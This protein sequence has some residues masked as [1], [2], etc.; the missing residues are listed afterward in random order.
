[1][2]SFVY[3]ELDT[4]PPEI[5]IFAPSYT[6]TEIV[7]TIRIETDEPL[8]DYQE[9]YAIDSKGIRHDYTF[10]KEEANLLIGE[11]SFFDFPLGVVTMYAIFKDEVDNVSDLTSVSIMIRENLTL[12][13][14][15]MSDSKRNMNIKEYNYINHISDYAK[16]IDMKDWSNNVDINDHAEVVVNTRDNSKDI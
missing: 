10:N 13:N 14:L 2:T 16:N 6:T 11:V 15:K 1:M 5:Q 7:N 12:L 9:I 3:I 8:S 4:N